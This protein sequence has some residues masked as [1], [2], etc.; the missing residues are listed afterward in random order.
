[1][2]LKQALDSAYE[3]FLQNDVPSPRLNAELLLMFV[4]GCDRAYLF[5]HPERVL[6]PE[7]QSQYDEV[8]HERARGCPTQYITGHQEFWGLALLVSP[9]VLITRPETEHVVETVLE[10]VKERDPAE[11]LKLV[12][13]GT[14]SGA[15]EMAPDSELAPD[16]GQAS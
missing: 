7:E 15:N 2:Q 9:A 4:L 12:D 5:A 13:I 16:Q 8:V 1:M 14:G 3:F 10:L 6:R 11:K